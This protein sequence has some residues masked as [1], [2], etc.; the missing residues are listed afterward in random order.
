MT[1]VERFKLALEALADIGG[2][3]DLTKEEL[4]RKARRIY[5]E[6]LKDQGYE[7]EDLFEL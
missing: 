1:D 5:N 2:S 4:Q 7:D 3:R 6:I